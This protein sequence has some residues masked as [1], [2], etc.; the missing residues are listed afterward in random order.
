MGLDGAKLSCPGSSAV[1]DDGSISSDVL[2]D[3]SP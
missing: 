3:K 2:P 1:A